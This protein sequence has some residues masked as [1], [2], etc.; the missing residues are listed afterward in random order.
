MDR[1]GGQ[2]PASELDLCE[3]LNLR[4]LG[5]NGAVVNRVESATVSLSTW[6]RGRR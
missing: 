4:G 3:V 2:S 5:T 1:D 6:R